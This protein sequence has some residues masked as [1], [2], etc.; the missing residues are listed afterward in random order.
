M[1]IHRAFAREVLHTCG[2]IS[3]VLL[4]IFTVTRLVGFLRQAAEGDIPLNSVLL[5]LLL[6]MIT[7]LDI[8]IPLTLYISTLFVMGRWVRDNELTVI[9]ACGIGMY[10]FIRPA[11]MLFAI[12]GAISALFSLYL[13]PL[14]IEAS[15]TIS[16][17][18]RNQVNVLDIMP[19]VFTETKDG[20]SVYFVDRL[21]SQTNTFRNL[22]IHNSRD[23]NQEILVADAG[24]MALA[25]HDE[26]SDG[27]FLVL[28]GGSRYRA[29][30]GAADYAVVDFETYR[31][32]MK[33]RTADSRKL[34]IKAIPTYKLLEKS[35]AAAVGEFHW[36]ISKVIMLP[37]LLL[38]ALA[39]SSITYRKTRF[40]AML[41]A[42]LVYFAYTNALGFG[43]VLIRRATLEPHST[44]W[45]IHLI[46]L[47]LAL[48][49][50]HRRNQNQ[51]LLPGLSA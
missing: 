37:I 35:N 48:Y 25:D 41:S 16:H 11:A 20:R 18:L 49:L 38:F 5:L 14:S 7:Y 39:F 34:P 19:G 31:L 26:T 28:Q 15:R 47:A 22:F 13:S 44:L 9:N 45:V 50:L 33:P 3:I 36:R 42:L 30:A 29:T 51:R 21:D 1:I 24:H 10:Q 17:E 12:V 43:V 8:L 2:A 6:K 27:D 23:D 40:P 4:S 32:R 46:F